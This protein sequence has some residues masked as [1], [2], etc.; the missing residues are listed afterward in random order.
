VVSFVARRGEEALSSLGADVAM[1]RIATRDDAAVG[2]EAVARAN[3]RRTWAT[4]VRGAM[5]NVV[6]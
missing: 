1:H 4:R 3:G 2:A 5:T 6:V